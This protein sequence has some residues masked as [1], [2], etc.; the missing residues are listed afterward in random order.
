VDVFPLQ[1]EAGVGSGRFDLPPED[2]VALEPGPV[3]TTG[4]ETGALKLIGDILRGL[5]ESGARRVPATHR[6]VRDDVDSP[7]NVVRG[8]GRGGISGGGG[9]LPAQFCGGTEEQQESD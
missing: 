8:D 4:R 9:G 3:F 7:L 5:L 2:R 6:I 1:H